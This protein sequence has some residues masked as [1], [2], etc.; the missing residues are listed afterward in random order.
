[1]CI[2]IYYDIV[3]NVW[4]LISYNVLQENTPL[5]E[6]PKRGLTSVGKETKIS[7]QSGQSASANNGMI[8][9]IVTM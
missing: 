9:P 2:Y 1:M 3:Y 7:N 5:Y 6:Q 4:F 8:K